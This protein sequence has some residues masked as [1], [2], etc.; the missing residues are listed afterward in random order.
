M[1]P[2]NSSGP[3]AP[4]ILGAPTGEW[5]PE[6]VRLDRDRDVV[7]PTPPSALEERPPSRP[8]V[9]PP[10][11]PAPRDPHR[12]L[13]PVASPVRDHHGP[14]RVLQQV[15]DVL[16]RLQCGAGGRRQNRQP[17]IARTPVS[18]GTHGPCPCQ[19]VQVLPAG[20]HTRVLESVTAPVHPTTRAPWCPA[21]ALCRGHTSADHWA[22]G[23]PSRSAHTPP[24]DP[25]YT[26][27]VCLCRTHTGLIHLSG[28]PPTSGVYV[29]QC[30]VCTR[31][32]T[33][34][35]GWSLPGT[36]LGAPH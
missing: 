25:L 31:V 7:P 5:A 12:R 32:C 27:L 9:Q 10:A 20:A 34:H 6:R 28:H 4:S 11:T 33:R 8:P 13:D 23:G 15:L 18:T 22:P 29:S 1:S 26:S 14:P 17:H 2:R 35:C 24:K 30:P 16:P 21:L 3:P 19:G 36:L